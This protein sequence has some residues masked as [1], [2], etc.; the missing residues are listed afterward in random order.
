LIERWAARH[1]N[2]D[3]YK[4]IEFIIVPANHSVNLVYYLDIVLDLSKK[5][6]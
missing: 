5:I 2:L 3:V 1:L 4:Y 6:S